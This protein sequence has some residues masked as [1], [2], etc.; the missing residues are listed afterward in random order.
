MANLK[1]SQKHMRQTKRRTA[2][3]DRIRNRVKRAVKSFN[4]L[5]TNED[6]KGAK[7]DLPKVSKVIAKAA[8]KNVIEDGT[9]SRNIS[10]LT[11]KLNKLITASKNVKT[12]KKS[13]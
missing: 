5:I 7:R 3:N 9:A 1:A 10:R 8:Q 13:S 11:Q 2:Y 4:I 6:V 12:A